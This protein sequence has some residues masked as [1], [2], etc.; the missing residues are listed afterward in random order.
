MAGKD[1]ETSVKRTDG[2]DATPRIVNADGWDSF[3]TN[4]KKG[5]LN[6]VSFGRGLSLAK[7]QIQ[8]IYRYS[9][10]ARKVVDLP[11][12]EMT[13]QWISIEGDE[14][15]EILS[16]MEELGARNLFREALQWADMFGGSMMVMIIDDG[17]ALDQ[18]LNEEAIRDIVD[19]RVYDRHQ[20][21]WGLPDLD[22]DLMS[23][24]FGKPRIYTINP[25]TS[26]MSTSFKIHYTRVLRFDGDDLP[27]RER[28]RNDGWGDSV[29]HT[30]YEELRNLGIVNN[31]TASIVD[32]F[33]QT[34]VQID[35]LAELIASGQDDIIKKRLEIINMGRSVMRTILLDKEESYTKEASTVAGLGDLIDRAMI[36]LA[37][38]RGIPV[39]KLF[40]RS[41]AGQNSTGEN[42]IRN[43][44]DEMKSK[45]EDKLLPPLE[46]FVALLMKALDGPFN[47][48]PPE[49]WSVTFNPLWQMSEKE[50]VDVR[51]I[52]AE[53]DK[54]YLDT[55]VL[56]PTEV[57]NARFGGDRYSPETKLDKKFREADGSLP[58]PEMAPTVDKNGKVIE[59]D[60][61]A[62]K[63]KKGLFGG[64]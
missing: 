42:D 32:D 33:V 56:D 52:V 61:N 23:R 28:V 26:G 43:F 18:P 62:P 4:V 15:G 21:S 63:K 51:K 47:G 39:T 35:N 49:D 59:P 17:G 50:T 14:D 1:T 64:K 31:A 54:I 6:S 13:R 44:Y 16:R 5:R 12:F 36:M 29:Y 11:A 40:G 60:P 38:V 45:Q 19:L 34:I 41:A 3:Y 24:N 53:T 9:G 37:G 8:E 46:R 57:A 2:A 20:V 25:Y 48:K 22:D 30:C 7:E 58:V 10:F 55:T 27:E